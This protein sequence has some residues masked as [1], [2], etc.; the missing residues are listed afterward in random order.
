M[1]ESGKFDE[2]KNEQ[3]SLYAPY[4]NLGQGHVSTKK[5]Y[6][7]GARMNNMPQII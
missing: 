6:F 5:D 3:D 2:F 4:D 1:L 7:I